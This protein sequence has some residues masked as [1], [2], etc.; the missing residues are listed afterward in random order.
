MNIIETVTEWET[1][2]D[3]LADKDVFVI[4]IFSDH[5]THPAMNQACVFGVFSAVNSFL[6]A[7]NHNEVVNLDI[8]VLSRLR[9]CRR[10]WT[11]NKKR[12]LHIV[13]LDNIYDLSSLEYLQFKAV[14][15]DEKFF[16]SV[17]R[18]MYETMEKQKNLNKAVPI[19]QHIVYMESVFAHFDE[20]V[21]NYQYLITEPQYKF[22]NDIAIPCLWHLERPGIAV[23]TEKLI[24]QYGPRVRR[25]VDG[26][27]RVY[28]EYNPYTTT[29]RVSNRY[30]NINF[31]A[32]NKKDGVREIFQSR[33]DNGM[34]VMMDFESFHLR[35]IADIIGYEFPPNQ[36]VHE[37]LGQQYFGKDKLTPEEYEEGKAITFSLL[38]GESRDTNVPEF[39]RKVYDYIDMLGVLI[40]MNGYVTSPY[41]KRKIYKD[42]IEDVT[43]SK[44]FN[45]IIQLAETERNLK[46]MLEMMPLFEGK[47]SV[48]ILY[49]YDSVLFDYSIEDGK[50]LIQSVLRVLTEGGKYPMR[51]YY[52]MTY[53]EMKRL[54]I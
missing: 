8:S 53:H 36:P 21:K 25:Y 41:F 12:L 46:M 43:P 29:G 54:T 15:G 45:Y 19:M 3:G 47:Q 17:H 30:G 52:G 9:V 42:D 6:I 39:F 32:L 27:N 13:Q 18:M 11:P 23:N 5:K 26:H 7:C 40:G 16:T 51:V 37:H 22:L 31:A 48:P 35:L 14:A 2:T 20:L 38:Y 50:E 1:V 49:T 4:P 33:F 24:D 44:I 28:T 34:L 10:V